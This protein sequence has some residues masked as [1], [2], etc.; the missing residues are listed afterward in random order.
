MWRAKSSRTA[1]SRCWISSLRFASSCSRFCVSRARRSRPLTK[2]CW[3]R[4][5]TMS[6]AA[7][8]NMFRF[9][10]RSSSSWRRWISPSRCSR[11]AASFSANL[12]FASSFTSCSSRAIS[13]SRSRCTW[14][15][16]RFAAYAAVRARRITSSLAFIAFSLPMRFWMI[17]WR[18]SIWFFFSRISFIARRSLSSRSDISSRSPCPPLSVGS[19]CVT[20][21]VG[22][23]SRARICAIRSFR[24]FC[25][26][27]SS[28]LL[29]SSRR[30]CS[31]R[32]SRLATLFLR[33]ILARTM[34]GASRVSWTSHTRLR[35]SS[36]SA[37]CVSFRVSMP[38]APSSRISAASF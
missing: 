37:I 19:N 10:T 8:R 30:F 6:L 16:L 31:A 9:C 21:F 3:V 29:A 26:S 24:R 5:S 25:S 1:I 20:R 17:F 34:A 11:I 2:S 14:R 32:I 13:A 28:S 36:T 23:R 33:S 7:P 12:I 4:C 22:T 38:R 15:A 18:S 35:R 27:S